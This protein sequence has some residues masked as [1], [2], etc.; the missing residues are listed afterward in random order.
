MQI[1]PRIQLIVPNA[2]YVLLF[3]IYYSRD[4]NDIKTEEKRY[5]G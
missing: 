1:V 4:F 5:K 3:L 2:G